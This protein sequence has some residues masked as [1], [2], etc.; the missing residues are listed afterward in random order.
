MLNVELELSVLPSG[1]C[2]P[3]FRLRHESAKAPGT[4]DTSG[5]AVWRCSRQLLLLELQ[6]HAKD[7]ANALQEIAVSCLALLLDG[8]Q[9]SVFHLWQ[10]FKGS[11]VALIGRPNSLAKHTEGS[12]RP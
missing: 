12:A 9:E 4:E 11:S 6:H 3:G 2:E 1:L 10:G 5:S 8:T 7:R